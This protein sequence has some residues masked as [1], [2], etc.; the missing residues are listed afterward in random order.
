M[1]GVRTDREIAID[2]ARSVSVVAAAMADLLEEG[3]IDAAMRLEVESLSQQRRFLVE[4]LFKLEGQWS[5]RACRGWK[6]HT[7]D[8]PGPDIRD[9]GEP[10]PAV[11]AIVRT[12][13]GL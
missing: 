10:P 1:S 11:T 2:C 13:P 9:P 8:C 7:P 5:C 6:H 4:Y 3:R 12:L